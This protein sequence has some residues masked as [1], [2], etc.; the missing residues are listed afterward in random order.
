MDKTI[1]NTEKSHKNTEKTPFFT[2]KI[3]FFT[4]KTRKTGKSLV[5]TIPFF[6]IENQLVNENIEYIIQMKVKS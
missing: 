6:L 2:E 1:E 3:P 5:I 4:A